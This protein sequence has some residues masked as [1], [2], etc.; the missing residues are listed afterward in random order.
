MVE[1]RKVYNFL[2]F[3]EWIIF[4]VQCT[5]SCCFWVLRTS[6]QKVYNSKGVLLE[7]CFL[8]SKVKHESEI[9]SSKCLFCSKS[10]VLFNSMADLDRCWFFFPSHQP[11]T[12]ALFH[13]IHIHPKRSFDMILLCLLRLG[14]DKHRASSFHG[15]KKLW[16]MAFLFG[17][18]I[19]IHACFIVLP[20]APIAPFATIVW[21]DLIIIVL[22][23]ASALDWYAV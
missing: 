4:A 15:Q 13:A 8:G 14:E 12:Q 22:G 10:Y 17:L 16:L 19:V 2:D 6:S 23:W 5:W 7:V 1:T 9:M 18:S 20:A 3:C 21:S 11:G